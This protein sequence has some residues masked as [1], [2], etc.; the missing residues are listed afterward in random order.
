MDET[1]KAI[2]AILSMNVEDTLKERG[3]RYGVFM[4]NACTAQLLKREMHSNPNWS[5]LQADQ[6]EALDNIQQ[7]IARILSGDPN[8]TDNWHDIAG[9]AKLVEDRIQ[10]EK[11]G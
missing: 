3:K 9:Y 4:T 2:N 11:K 5:K 8:Y 7:K 6:Q 1:S 10:K